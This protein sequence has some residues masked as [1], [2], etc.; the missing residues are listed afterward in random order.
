MFAFAAGQNAWNLM[1]VVIFHC[2]VAAWSVISYICRL[3]YIA[4]AHSPHM[5]LAKE[6]GFLKISLRK[7]RNLGI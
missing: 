2:F 3:N 6:K 1:F 5:N 4:L 7:I